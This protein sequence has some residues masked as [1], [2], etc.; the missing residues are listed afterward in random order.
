MD[1]SCLSTEP[2]S[3]LRL[4]R[5][6]EIANAITHA[7]GLMLS[8]TGAVSMVTSV[9][10]SGDGWR[11]AGCTI[12]LASL[13]AVYSM[14]TLSHSCSSP[15]WREWFR[16]LDQGFI[17]FLIAATYTPFSMAFLRTTPWW[18]LLGLIWSV[19]LYGFI[20]KVVFG[21]RVDSVAVWPCIL[22]G[23]MPIISVPFLAHIVPFGAFWWT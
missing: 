13:V 17:Y 2:T 15:E 11:V 1:R 23:W 21:H 20:S 9:A 16:K 4:S 14:S 3:I 5:G 7:I 6:E 8:V 22:L 19:A 10:G 12:Y 18:L